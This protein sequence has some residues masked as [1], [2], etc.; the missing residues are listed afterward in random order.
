MTKK[1]SS[2]GVDGKRMGD[3]RDYL[4]GN[5][6]DGWYG[7]VNEEYERLVLESG[8]T[9]LLDEGVWEKFKFY[10]GKLGSLEKGGKIMGGGKRRKEQR[11]KLQAA[12]KGASSKV[13]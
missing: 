2:F 1:F 8:D 3:W 7:L 11:E 13:N 9:Y 12:I 6:V 10:A 4:S 5:K